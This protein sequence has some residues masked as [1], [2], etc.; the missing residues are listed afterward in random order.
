MKGIHVI[1]VINNIVAVFLEIAVV[2]LC[3]NTRKSILIIDAIAFDD[4][5]QSGLL[6]RQNSDCQIAQC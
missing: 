4:T 3:V 2:F 1:V 6:F 5:F